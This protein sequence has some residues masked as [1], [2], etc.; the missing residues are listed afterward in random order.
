MVTPSTHSP[1]GV[2]VAQLGTPDA[3]TAKALR[4]YL[5]Q[6]L[7]DM[8]VIDYPPYIWQPILQG[9]ILNTRPRRSARLY[10]RIWLP[11]G[12]PLLVYSQQQAAGLQA[13]LGDGYRVIVGM[14]YGNP[15]IDAAMQAFANEG[16]NRVIVLPMFPQ[17]SCAT[18][19]SIYDA[20]YTAAAGRRCPLFHDRRRFV[21]TLRFVEPYF[22]HP[23][24]LAAM[25]DHLQQQI[26]QLDI[27]PD[28]FV[29]TF[30]GIPKRYVDSGDPYRAQCERTAALLAQAMGWRDD[31]WLLCF[32]SRF[33][34]EKWLEPYTDETLESLAHRGVKRPLVFSPGFVTDCLETLDELG[35]E[36]RDQFV[37]GGGSAGHYHLAPCLN[38]HPAWL[39]AMAALVHANA[40][41]WASAH[42]QA[43]DGQTSLNGSGSDLLARP[44]AE[45]AAD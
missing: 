39:D 38:A 44:R 15:S 30:H 9:I 10:Q 24:Y 43:V 6:F 28:K 27:S 34:P 31:E 13:R 42:V 23:L 32:Q 2:L 3:P 19:A 36:G 33:G 17:F 29:I 18:T 20:V 25:K 1:V 12:S 37:E 21:P 26:A 8:R 7:S 35:N 4:P 22:D 11:E 40:A 14:R 45:V 5:K 16:I 41:G